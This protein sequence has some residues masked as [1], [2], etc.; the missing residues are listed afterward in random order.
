M[1]EQHT[2][3][4]PSTASDEP[5]GRGRDSEPEQTQEAVPSEEMPSPGALIGITIP[6]AP[7][8]EQV[9]QGGDNA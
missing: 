4:G 7:D 3:Q 1:Q 9:G 5:N 8:A 6:V 2:Y